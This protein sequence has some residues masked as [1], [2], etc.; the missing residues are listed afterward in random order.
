M[1]QLVVGIDGGTAAIFDA[2]DMPFWQSLRNADVTFDVT[3][4]LNQ[5]GWARMLSGQDASENGG[6]YMRPNFDGSR[7]FDFSFNYEMMSAAAKFRPIWRLAEDAGDRVGMM[8]VPTTSPAQ[9]VPGF[10]VAGG[11]GGIFQ[12][13]LPDGAVYPKALVSE[14][15]QAGYIFDT[16]P[17]AQDFS[18]VRD[19]TQ[20]I[21]EMMKA[22][23][24]TFVKLAKSQEIDFGFLAYRATTVLL[25]LGM[26]EVAHAMRVPRGDTRRQSWSEG[27]LAIIESHLRTLDDCLAKLFDEL[28]PK[29]HIVTSDH[30]IVPWTHNVD[31][32]GFLTEAGLAEFGVSGTTLAKSAAKLVLRPR[33]RAEMA[34]VPL[35]QVF[36]ATAT[37]GRNTKNQPRAFSGTYVYG[38][39]VNDRDRFGGPVSGDALGAETDGI[40]DSFNWIA[41]QRQIP[42]QAVRYR[43]TFGDAP[44][45]RIL[46]DVSILQSGHAFP[47]ILGSHW[48]G[49]NHNFGPVTT[50]TGA[51]GMHS[52]QKGT[53]PILMADTSLAALKSENDPM[54]L[55]LVYRLTAKLYGAK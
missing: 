7:T 54:D 44:Q 38:I 5:R 9:A 22:R 28:Q 1:K 13:G 27:W 15:E 2:F 36:R 46:P 41:Q 19:L 26:S 14:I 47:S 37:A 20:H 50:L 10:Y 17:G 53:K 39:Y 11:G 48:Y 49:R 18:S 52:G 3:E 31:F 30:S 34:D 6:L 12:G 21:E 8:N 40:I 45:A 32:N 42:M 51:G 43:S 29:H 24:S 55:R 16:R 23:T 33:F 35:R 4:D 25:F